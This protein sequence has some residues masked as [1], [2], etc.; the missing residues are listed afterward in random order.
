ML[1]G[2][3]A[4]P[5]TMLS[6]DELIARH[7][8]NAAAIPRLWAKAK[9]IVTFSNGLSW[10]SALLPPNGTLL[11][12]KGPN[13]LGPHYLVL[14]GKEAGNEVFRLGSSPEQG[15]YY[16]WARWGEKATALVGRYKFAGA[17][18][19]Q[20][21]PIDPNQV[22]AILGI[23]A[24]P[25]DLTALPTVALSMSRNPCAYVVTYID[26][27]PLTDRILFRKEIY[28]RWS[29]TEPP[30]P[31]LV[32]LFDAEGRRVLSARLKK[33]K[34]IGEAGGTAPVMPTDIRIEWVDWP[35]RRREVKSVR[36]ILSGMTTQQRGDPYDQCRFE[37]DRLPAGVKPVLIDRDLDGGGKA[38]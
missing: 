7:N 17:P 9:I 37:P 6:L 12:A 5:R 2:C 34:R 22:L 4:C 3:A 18:G 20:Q 35:D 36:L 11:L 8:A 25:N 30:R 29:E 10:G 21:P 1:A 14:V 15:L 19:I 38:P 16:F 23:F 24:L 26:R 32:N 33:Y 28:F 13:P 31:F 27:Q